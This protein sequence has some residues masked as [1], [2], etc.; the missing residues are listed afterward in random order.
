MK[1]NSWM[2]NFVQTLSQKFINQYTNWRNKNIFEWE[3]LPLSTNAF[4]TFQI[5]AMSNVLDLRLPFDVIK[6]F[7]L[8]IPL[9]ILQFPMYHLGLE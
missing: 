6:L 1:N 8:G 3:T 5:N 4:Y 9:G 7:V 2:E